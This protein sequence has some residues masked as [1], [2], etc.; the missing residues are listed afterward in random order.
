[1]SI[2]R[3][4]DAASSAKV[5]ALPMP[6]AAG[7]LTSQPD[8][9]QI[10]AVVQQLAGHVIARGALPAGQVIPAIAGKGEA[11][12]AG[13]AAP[14]EAASSGIDAMREMVQQMRK[15]VEANRIA[16]LQAGGHIRQLN[17]ILEAQGAEQLMQPGIGEQAPAA[18]QAPTGPDPAGSP[19]GADDAAAFKPDQELETLSTLSKHMDKVPANFSFGD[20]DAM[21]KDQ[22][23]PPDLREAYANLRANPALLE[24]LDNGNL[25]SVGRVKQRRHR[26][27]EVIDHASLRKAFNDPALVEYN[28][29]KA[30]GYTQNYIPSDATPDTAVPRQMTASDAARELYLYSDSLG[31]TVDRAELQRIVDGQC[32]GKCPAQLQAAAK[33]LL[34]NPAAFD[35][36]APGGKVSQ[37]ALEN[38]AVGMV[39]LRQDEADALRTLQ[40]NKDVFFREGEVVTRDSLT[41]LAAD[42]TVSAEVRNA[43]ATML[44]NP[45]LFGM[46]DN[47]DKGAEPSRRNKAHDGKISSADVDQ[48]IGKLNPAAMKPPAEPPAKEARQ[49]PASALE[50]AAVEDMLAGTV[51][52]PAAKVS[53]G[54]PKAAAIFSKVLD[55]VGK[56]LDWVKTGL[57]TLASVLPPPLGTIA[58]AIGAGVAAVNNLAVKPGEAMLN[59]VPPKE[60]YKQAG[61]DLAFDLASSA[62]SVIPAGGIGAKAALQGAKA[63]VVGGVKEGV[64][65]AVKV[66]VR[67]VGEAVGQQAIKESVQTIGKAVAKDAVGGAVSTA[68]KATVK[69]VAEETSKTTFRQ[70]L[71]EAARDIVIDE[72]TLQT[73]IAAQ[74]QLQ[75]MAAAQQPAASSLPAAAGAAVAAGEALAPVVSWTQFMP[76]AS[77]PSAT[78]PSLDVGGD[79]FG[80]DPFGDPFGVEDTD[81]EDE[82]KEEAERR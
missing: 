7:P 76:G 70:G 31:K 53:R 48:L 74:R 59:G 34:D 36:L 55:V 18:A 13:D 10:S 71:K 67:E 16:S 39:Q 9:A 75:S 40:N 35:K 29:Q 19:P 49:G 81:E 79:P 28:R 26:D 38:N 5:A 57:D 51:D 8:V 64:E 50:A 21:S 20:L 30:E 69:E 58:G 72:V 4:L 24:R 61:K 77:G 25:D 66:G 32:R 68:A 43:A 42:Q 46:L 65:A 15:D 6:D 12:A 2:S 11:G 82:E 37:G 41:N 45:L 78:M 73:Q 60:A 62:L 27:D 14:R 47:G 33:F 56:A 23:L 44:A 52:D 63:A 17:A 80:K 3:P 1:M 22:S 54:G